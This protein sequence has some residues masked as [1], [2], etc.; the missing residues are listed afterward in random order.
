MV[1]DLQEYVE[2]TSTHKREENTSVRVPASVCEPDG[3]YRA[4][5][6]I[7]AVLASPPRVT[8]RNDVV[9]S[10]A[11]GIF[12]DIELESSAVRVPTYGNGARKSTTSV[13]Q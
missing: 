2:V 13:A 7:T 4:L 3:T 9:V 12:L 8:K 11:T 1:V 10:F 6:S 5:T